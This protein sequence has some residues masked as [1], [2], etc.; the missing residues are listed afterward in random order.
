MLKFNNLSYRDQVSHFVTTRHGGVSVGEFTSLNL[1][2][3]VGDKYKNVERNYEILAGELGILPSDFVIAKQT[4]SNN[5]I[6]V[7]KNKKRGY[8]TVPGTVLEDTDAMVTAVGG[9][10]LMVRTAD[11]VPLLLFDPCRKVVAAVHAGW[12]G[13]VKNVAGKT[14]KVMHERFGT[15]PQD[16]EAGIGPSAG[17]CCYE[18]GEEVR[19]AVMKMP[20]AGERVITS[21]ASRGRYYFDMRSANRQT[22]LSA[23]V[24]PDGIEVINRCTICESGNFF[25]VRAAKGRTGRMGAGIL[26]DF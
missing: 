24:N 8:P 3:N 26:L 17:P 12:R 22:L 23:G 20:V 10:C 2:F 13:T 7:E 5:V 11:C 16:I 6:V 25:S 18:V 19:E 1:G 14:L 21:G 4:H 9:I 15:R